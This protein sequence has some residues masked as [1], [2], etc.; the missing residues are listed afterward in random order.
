MDGHRHDA[1]PDCDIRGDSDQLTKGGKREMTL[2]IIE[3]DKRKNH[4]RIAYKGVVVADGIRCPSGRIEVRPREKHFPYHRT[5]RVLDEEQLREFVL[6][7]E[8]A[9]ER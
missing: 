5:N 8:V 6:L 3:H 7:S 4:L 1:V 9:K 2:E